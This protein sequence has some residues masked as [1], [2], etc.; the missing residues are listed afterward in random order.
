[1]YLVMN[2]TKDSLKN[3]PG[4]KYDS[5]TTTWVPENKK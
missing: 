2:A 4:F 1:M 5:N 3:A